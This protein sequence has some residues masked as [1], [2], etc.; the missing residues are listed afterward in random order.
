[1]EGSGG[2]E[3]VGGRVFPLLSLSLGTWGPHRVPRHREPGN[4]LP[5]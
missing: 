5:S 1:M 2:R 3:G 4:K